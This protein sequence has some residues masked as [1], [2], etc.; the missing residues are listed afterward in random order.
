MKKIIAIVIALLLFTLTACGQNAQEPAGGNTQIPNP[1]VDCT[2]LADAA[3][4]AG[5]DIAVPG[6][7]KGYPNKLIQAMEKSM[8]QV[9]YFD[10]DPDAETS[11]TL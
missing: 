11:S 9:L 5:F 6:S 7:I 4:L 2:T 1:W 3:K 8:I 10:G